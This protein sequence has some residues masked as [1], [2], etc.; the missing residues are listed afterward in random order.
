MRSYACHLRIWLIVLVPLSVILGCAGAVDQGQLLEDLFNDPRSGWGEDQREEFYR[1]YEGGEYIIELYEPN[2]V[3]WAHPGA[4]FGD[5]RV[6][7]DAHLASGSPDNHFGLLCRH[8]DADNYYYFAI[9]SD[10]YYAIYRR[11]DGGKLE[12]LT[13]GGGMVLSRAIEQGEPVNHLEA[14]CHGDK[15]SLVVNGEVLETVTDNALGRGDVGVGAGSG[16]LGDV[17]IHFDNFVAA[18]P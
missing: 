2:W 14:V 18:E 15:L 4:Q 3:I 17:R 10:G 9:S 5:V 7:V 16:T 8:V 12:V 13:A 6:E 11:V 1:G